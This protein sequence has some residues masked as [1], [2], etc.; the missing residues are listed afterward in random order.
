MHGLLHGLLALHGRAQPLLL[1]ELLLLELLQLLLRRHA[2]LLLLPLELLEHH[3][4][5]CCVHVG[6]EAGGRPA[7]PWLHFVC[8]ASLWR[9]CALGALV[10][11]SQR[12]PSPP[13]IPLSVT[14][15]L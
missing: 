10:L 3:L 1:L 7:G 13:C 14:E 2:L 8:G 12:S 11:S 15:C 5:L 9:V 6:W 4:D